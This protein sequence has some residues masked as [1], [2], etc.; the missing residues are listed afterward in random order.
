[1]IFDDDDDG[2]D[3]GDSVEKLE[4]IKPLYEYI[5]SKGE[6]CWINSSFDLCIGETRGG[7][8]ITKRLEPTQ[9]AVDAWL[10][11]RGVAV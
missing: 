1:V 2:V 10:R 4:K 7:V 8:N 11:S 3:G 6:F 5:L 9:E